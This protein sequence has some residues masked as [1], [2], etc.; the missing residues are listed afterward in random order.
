MTFTDRGL[1]KAKSTVLRDPFSAAGRWQMLLS[2]WYSWKARQE[3]PTLFS[4]SFLQVG[5]K[6]SCNLCCLSLAC[7]LISWSRECY[8]N[9]LRNQTMELYKFQH[10]RNLHRCSVIKNFDRSN[11]NIWLLS[12]SQFGCIGNYVNLVDLLSL[13]CPHHSY[14]LCNYLCTNLCKL[15]NSDWGSE[16]LM[17]QV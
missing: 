10:Q 7:G 14:N 5:E 11:V 16:R 1:N 9:S 13:N 6:I 3:P 12:T 4:S 8:K 17:K 15:C 2:R